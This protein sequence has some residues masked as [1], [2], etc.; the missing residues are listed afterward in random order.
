MT[1]D[2]IIYNYIDIYIIQ[3]ARSH[4]GLLFEDTML[5]PGMHNIFVIYINL[6]YFF[7]VN[8]LKMRHH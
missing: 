3:T 1:V 4:I 5:F 2:I 8:G 7:N 6:M